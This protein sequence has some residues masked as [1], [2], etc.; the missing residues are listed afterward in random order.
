M[1]LGA[2]S[3]GSGT[4]RPVTGQMPVAPRV[5]RVYRPIQDQVTLAGVGNAD[6]TN[7]LLVQ[8]CDE[9][10]R[11]DAEFVGDLEMGEPRRVGANQRR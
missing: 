2:R 7:R 4:H 11:G 1:C 3:P 10:V 5:W 8:T 9:L 6:D